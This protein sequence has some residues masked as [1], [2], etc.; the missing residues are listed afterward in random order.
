[1]AS[2]KSQSL[3]PVIQQ[4]TPPPTLPG[5]HSA[6]VSHGIDG[7]TTI[8]LTVDRGD[9]RDVLDRWT[10]SQCEIVM[11]SGDREVAFR[12]PKMHESPRS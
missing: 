6:V 9:V 4:M 8:T 1:M 2:P 11:R 7:K 5:S 10:F 12:F 3:Q